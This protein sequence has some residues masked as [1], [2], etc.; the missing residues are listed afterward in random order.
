MKLHPYLAF[1]GQCSAAF[2]FYAQAL[3]GTINEKHCYAGSPMAEHAG[4]DWADKVMHM[5]LT[6][7]GQTLL[8][9]DSLEPH[10]GFHGISL[11]LQVDSAEAAERAFAAISPNATIRMPIQK[12]FWAERFGMLIDQFGVNWSVN[13]DA[14]EQG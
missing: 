5:S 11:V 8:G 2:D 6:F 12:T 7:N 4:P 14:V 1:H 13:C 3:G 9:C 10:T